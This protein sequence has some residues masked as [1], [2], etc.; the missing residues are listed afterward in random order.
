[1]SYINIWGQ[2][3]ETDATNT[4]MLPTSGSTDYVIDADEQHV[5]GVHIPSNAALPAVAV[6]SDGTT[7]VAD[8]SGVASP[9]APQYDGSSGSAGGFPETHT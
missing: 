9:Y 6:Q 3:V 8:A 7:P 2:T 1:M 4:G 5:G